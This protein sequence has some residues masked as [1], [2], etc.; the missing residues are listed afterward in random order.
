MRM[1]TNK[2][3]N[4][5]KKQDLHPQGEKMIVNGRSRPAAEGYLEGEQTCSMTRQ[6]RQVVRHW[7]WNIYIVVSYRCSVSNKERSERRRMHR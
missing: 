5:Q 3:T 7:Q 1:K 6:A 2:H 4:K